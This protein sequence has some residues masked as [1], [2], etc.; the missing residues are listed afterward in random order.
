M[1]I[2][3]IETLTANKKKP[4]EKVAFFYLILKIPYRSTYSQNF[5]D[6]TPQLFFIGLQSWLYLKFRKIEN[7]KKW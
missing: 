6:V 2:R 5:T 3:K 1:K 7:L 4:I